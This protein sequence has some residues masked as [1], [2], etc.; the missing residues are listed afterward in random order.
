MRIS[1]GLAVVGAIVGDF[2]FRRGQPGL[3][4]LIN[5]Y[6]SRVQTPELFAAI[7]TAAI[8]GVAIFLIFGWIGRLAVGRW[9]EPSS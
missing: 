5:N 9:Y 8:L 7:I 2:F 3:G 4:I 1:A 6:A